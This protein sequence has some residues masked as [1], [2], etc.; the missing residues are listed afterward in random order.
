MVEMQG[1]ALYTIPTID[2]ILPFVN[3]PGPRICAVT[4]LHYSSNSE[5][6]LS[7]LVCTQQKPRAVGRATSFD[8][9]LVDGNFGAVSPLGR[10]H[11]SLAPRCCTS[12]INPRLQAILG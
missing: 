1:Q 9:W 7:R 6:A 5:I 4:L 8:V 2:L 11:F 3:C 12:Y 10:L